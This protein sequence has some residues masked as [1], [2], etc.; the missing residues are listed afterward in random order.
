MTTDETPVSNLDRAVD[1]MLVAMARL[2][3]LPAYVRKCK[4]LA[5]MASAAA[6]DAPADQ[7]PRMATLTAVI[8]S[9]ADVALEVHRL[10]QMKEDA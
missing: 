3:D 2:P 8:A 4:A 6:N 5:A 7:R 10:N 9:T 1:Q